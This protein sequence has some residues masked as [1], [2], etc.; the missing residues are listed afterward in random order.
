[1]ATK[2][3][4]RQTALLF[5]AY[6]RNDMIE[7][8]HDAVEQRKPLVGRWL[9][10]GTEP[11]YRPVLDAGL[12]TWACG[13]PAKRCMGWLKLTDKGAATMKEREQDFRETMNQL[14]GN[15]RYTKSAHANYM[16]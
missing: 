9:G 11:A 4:K 8:G 3:T 14:K 5:E 2:I 16:L 1:M 13:V 15:P 6:R 7:S 10:L 12:M